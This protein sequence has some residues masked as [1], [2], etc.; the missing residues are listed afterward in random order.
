[1][2]SS[3]RRLCYKNTSCI[4]FEG[5]LKPGDFINWHTET[6]K[7]VRLNRLSSQSYKAK[8]ELMTF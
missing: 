3:V 5:K 1:M 8:S 2:Y 6:V 7:Q 4:S